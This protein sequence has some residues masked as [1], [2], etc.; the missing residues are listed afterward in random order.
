MDSRLCF[1]TACVLFVL[2]YM[3]L[4]MLLL[5]GTMRLCHH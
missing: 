5:R 2:A 3:A 1:G 4:K